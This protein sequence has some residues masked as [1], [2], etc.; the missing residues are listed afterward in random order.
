MR[1]IYVTSEKFML[2]FI[3]SIQNNNSTQFAQAYRKVDILI[4]DDVQFFQTKE[5]TQIWRADYIQTYM[6]GHI[7]LL[8]LGG[9][10]LLIRTKT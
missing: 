1:V 5:Q 4:L 3:H 10:W 6:V 8:P 2:D 9:K 7:G